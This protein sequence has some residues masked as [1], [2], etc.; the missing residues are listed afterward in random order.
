MKSIKTHFGVI[1]SLVALLFSVQ[2]GIF[3]SNLTKSYERSIQNEYNIVLVSKTSLSLQDAQKAVPK[4]SSISEISTAGIT[5]RLK[6]KISQNAFAELSKNLPKFYSVKLES[7]PDAAQLAKIEQDLKSIGSL[8]RVEIFKKT[9]DEIFKI[10]LLIKSLVYG[11]AFLI[12]L[13]GVMLI[14]RQMR[15]WVYEH[16]ERIEI[17]ELFGASFLIKSGK[18][19]RMAIIDSFIATLIVTCFYIALSGWEVFSTTLKGIGDL[20]TAIVLPYDALIL[21]SVAL[22]LSIIAVSFVMLQ[23]GNKRA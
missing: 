5:E 14:H 11:F 18:L 17:M 16:K 4:I 12:V 15:I 2:F 21:L 6:G 3:M 13:L 8:T 9:H 7:F 19:Y 20:R 22:A 23:I 1:F 10:L